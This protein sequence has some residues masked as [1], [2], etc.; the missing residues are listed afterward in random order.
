MENLIHRFIQFLQ[1]FTNENGELIYSDAI[2]QMIEK[3]NRSLYVDFTQLEHFDP[4]LADQIIEHP[5]DSLSAASDG[6]KQITLIKEPEFLHQLENRVHIRFINPPERILKPLQ[7]IR[8]SDH[9]KY[10]ATEAVIVEVS[11]ITPIL[12]VAA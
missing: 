6:L 10:I 11:K 12:Q 9:G 4:H 1:E 5:K 8:P 3:G 2:N 7:K